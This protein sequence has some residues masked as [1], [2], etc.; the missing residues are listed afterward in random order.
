MRRGA[1]GTHPRLLR[2]LDVGL[3][4]RLRPGTATAPK[5][6]HRELQQSVPR[7]DRNWTEHSG[8][9]HEWFEI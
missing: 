8:L 3:F 7:I 5:K 1:V 4:R 9:V 2:L 6:A